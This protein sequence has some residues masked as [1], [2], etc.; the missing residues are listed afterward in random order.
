[1]LKDYTTKGVARTVAPLIEAQHRVIAN[2]TKEVRRLENIRRKYSRAL[3]RADTA[4]EQRTV[5][6]K[7]GQ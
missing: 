4:N 6:A 7:E 3:R 2:A 5:T 1:M